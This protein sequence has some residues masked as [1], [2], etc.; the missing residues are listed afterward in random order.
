M[1]DPFEGPVPRP[2]YQEYAAEVELG[3]AVLY[4]KEENF[5]SIIHFA[6]KLFTLRQNYLLCFKII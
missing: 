1:W 6:S 3:R 5:A 2:A 4:L